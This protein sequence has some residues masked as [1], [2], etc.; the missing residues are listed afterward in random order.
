MASISDS[1]ISTYDGE[2]LVWEDGAYGYHVMFKSNLETDSENGQNKCVN[3]TTGTTY[4]LD[5]THIPQDALIERAFLVWSGAVPIADLNEPTDNEVTL[6]YNSTDGEIILEE[7]VTAKKAYKTSEDGGF[8]FEG[9]K[10]FDNPNHS[11]FTYRVDVTYLFKEIHEAGRYLGF[12]HDGYSLYG[13]YNLSGLTCASDSSYIEASNMVSGWSIILIYTST[14]I[15][16]KNIYIYDEFAPRWHE[17]IEMNVLGFEF[18]TDPKVKITLATHEGD[19]NLASLE[20][21][22]GGPAIPEGIQVQGDQVGWLL[23]SNDCNPES[24]KTNG[25][26]TLFYTEVYNSISSVYG[27][28]DEK[29]TCIGGTPPVWDYETIEHGIDI[30]T[31]L[32][33]SSIDGSY[34]AH[35]NK[36]G[37]RIGLKIGANQDWYITNYMI[38]STDTKAPTFDIP[39]RAELVACT[40]ANE[41]GK[42]CENGEHTFA[43]RIQNWGNN[44]T[45]PV[46]VKAS[47][48]VGMEYIPGTTEYGAEFYESSGERVVHQWKRVPDLENNRFPLKEGFKVAE[49]TEFCDADDDYLTCYN[50]IM[51][52]Y[53]AKVRVDIQKHDVI[54]ASASIET[55]GSPNYKTNLGIPLILKNTA[56]G[57][58]FPN[59]YTDLS[60]CGGDFGPK[61]CKT[62]ADCAKYQYCDIEEGENYGI[63]REDIPTP[64]PCQND[65]T[66]SNKDIYPLDDIVYIPAEERVVLGQF[67]IEPSSLSDCAYRFS[68]LN[69]KFDKDDKNI[70]DSLLYLVWDINNDGIVDNEPIVAYPVNKNDDYTEIVIEDYFWANEVN[71][72]LIVGTMSYTGDNPIPGKASFTPSIEIDGIIIDDASNTEISGL[73]ITFNKFQLIPDNAITISRGEKDPTFKEEPLI[74]ENVDILQIKAISKGSND[75]IT[76]IKVQISDENM[77]QFGKKINRITLYSDTDNDGEKDE[78]IT[79]KTIEEITDKVELNVNIELEQ[80]AYQYYILSAEIELEEYDYFSFEIYEIETEKESPVFGVPIRSNQ[81]GTPDN[82]SSDEKNDFKTLGCG[83][84]II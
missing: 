69:I 41:D 30:D 75:K 67:S 34:A 3:E 24:Q 78:L 48:P 29:P 53:R 11:Y 40:P 4:T 31:F 26:N 56:T 63:C 5:S 77:V 84:S 66:I 80:D 62:D 65:Y 54:E 10:D 39:G 15:N 83:C 27:W 14:E 2:K 81:Y 6:K 28:N 58:D 33:D 25:I 42:W 32:L 70:V 82:S 22:N 57:C 35:F 12:E 44:I 74:S 17:Q 36:G 43:I 38:V 59:E 1:E 60:K 49:A 79:E 64:I 50:L 46:I 8:E 71:H 73:P 45:P 52:R 9:F 68:T 47:I 37:Q 61:I 55:T 72:F 19:P 18:P 76:K 23:L 51:V 7:T 13:D 21:P 16:T 20:N